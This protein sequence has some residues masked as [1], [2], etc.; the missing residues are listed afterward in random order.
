MAEQSN[1]ELSLH[2]DLSKFIGEW[3]AIFEGVVIAHGHNLKEVAL[4]AKE[5]CGNKKFLLARVP[6]EE[7][8]IF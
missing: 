8:M 2:T 3:V 1:Y 4:R 7:T 5:E 6:V